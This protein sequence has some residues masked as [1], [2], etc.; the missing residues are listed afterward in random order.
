MIAIRSGSGSATELRLGWLGVS[1]T[2]NMLESKVE[3]MVGVSPSKYASGSLT[4]LEAA[5]L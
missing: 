3:S 1:S 4:S 5:T 2:A